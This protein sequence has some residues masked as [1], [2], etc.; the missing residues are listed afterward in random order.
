MKFF[1]QGK[2]V[3]PPLVR[4]DKE[5]VSLCIM[6]HDIRLLDTVRMESLRDRPLFRQRLSQ[7][8]LVW[9]VVILSPTSN[10]SF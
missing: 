2:S 4:V 1:S 3:V 6:V 7:R 10:N 8:V 5:F 9:G